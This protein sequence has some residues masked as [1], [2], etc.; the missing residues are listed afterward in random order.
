MT[1]RTNRIRIL[2]NIAPQFT[3]VQIALNYGPHSGH[4]EQVG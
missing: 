4:R 2:R 3:G 1:K